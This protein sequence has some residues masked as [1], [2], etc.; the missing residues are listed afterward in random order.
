[1]KLRYQ[2]TVIQHKQ[3]TQLITP[4]TYMKGHGGCK[5]RTT[6]ETWQNFRNLTIYCCNNHLCFLG[7]M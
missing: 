7:H 1:M 6:S 2:G 4:H 3:T 5:L